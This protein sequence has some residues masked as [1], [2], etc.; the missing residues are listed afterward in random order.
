MANT[1]H[2][3][4]ML[5]DDSPDSSSTQHDIFGR[6]VSRTP[7]PGSPTPGTPPAYDHLE[8]FVSP[9][10]FSLLDSDF[11]HESRDVFSADMF[12]ATSVHD[13]AELPAGPKTTPVGPV[14][15]DSF[16]DISF[17]LNMSLDNDGLNMGMGSSTTTTTT[18]SLQQQQQ[19]SQF[20]D[21]LNGHGQH[22]QGTM[23]LGAQSAAAGT[24]SNPSTG[25]TP[26]A[27]PTPPS[28]TMTSSH[29]HQ[30]LYAHAFPQQA[31]G[32]C[33]H[34]AA[35]LAATC[36]NQLCCHH[37]ASRA[38][39]AGISTSSSRSTSRT[40][41]SSGSTPTS[42]HPTQQP[43]RPSSSLAGTTTSLGRLSD[44]GSTAPQ[45]RQPVLLEDNK[46]NPLAR[47]N[48]DD[49]SFFTFE[50]D[51]IPEYGTSHHDDLATA[52]AAEINDN[53]SSSSSSNSDAFASTSI[54]AS[55][56]SGLASDAMGA[57]DMQHTD[58]FDID[59]D[60]LFGGP[61]GSCSNPNCCSNKR[62]CGGPDMHPQ[63]Q[64]PQQQ[65][66]AYPHACQGSGHNATGTPCNACPGPCC[67]QAAGAM[68]H[69]NTNTNSSGALADNSTRQQP[70]A[71]KP[72]KTKKKR[73]TA[74]TRGSGMD[75]S[76]YGGQPATK[77]PKSDEGR[78]ASQVQHNAI[79]RARRHDVKFELQT[80]ACGLGQWMPLGKRPS[81]AKAM[82]SVSTDAKYDDDVM[83]YADLQGVPD[84]SSKAQVLTIS[85]FALLDKYKLAGARYILASSRHKHLQNLATLPLDK[86]KTAID[87]ERQKDPS[88]DWL[89]ERGKTDLRSYLDLICRLRGGHRVPTYHLAAVDDE[90]KG[91]AVTGR[92]HNNELTKENM[93]R[94]IHSHRLDP[95]NLRYSDPTETGPDAVDKKLRSANLV[96][97]EVNR[98]WADKYP[99]HQIHEKDASFSLVVIPP[100]DPL[101]LR[102]AG[103]SA[104]KAARRS[105]DE[106]KQKDH[107]KTERGRRLLLSVLQHLLS[108]AANTWSPPATPGA[109][110]RIT[111]EK[112]TLAGALDRLSE[113]VTC[114]PIHCNCEEPHQ[115][116]WFNGCW[117]DEH[118]KAF[119]AR[120]KDIFL[121][122]Q[123]YWKDVAVAKKKDAK[124]QPGSAPLRRKSKK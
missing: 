51:W 114:P 12:A 48:N 102:K 87:A 44:A 25:V 27:V 124:P 82:I 94:F 8:P 107:N 113:C 88:I 41:S 110:P 43:S 26:P 13:N 14:A 108:I 3:Y 117:T 55:S 1:V 115:P 42:I 20:A 4:M 50:D 98:L 104:S 56:E 60:C 80:L 75:D 78:T 32:H 90:F 29:Q 100:V 36:T 118:R 103:N 67:V 74:S 63:Q 66:Q 54:W 24:T 45:P 69:T 112:K 9:N 46:L 77:T 21:Y 59:D 2:S 70:G 109:I 116:F 120:R 96:I 83:R 58:L 47:N 16:V 99:H 105:S 92:P 72:K 23:T 34:H 106:R 53:N 17:N 123:D 28:Y 7:V 52:F 81:S 93:D 5:P 61:T 86:L 84:D 73:R 85:I 119:H 62:Q 37:S 101:S 91:D 19:A 57:A 65:Q 68:C 22:Q 76:L 18:N 15:D 40:S 31:S 111:A 38:C 35:A 39:P 79:E 11:A 122:Y 95:E 10:N 64:H 121:N 89:L 30:P 97:K 33:P 6:D 71:K 49:D